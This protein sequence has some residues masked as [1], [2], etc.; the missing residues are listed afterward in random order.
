MKARL[1]IA[2]VSTLLEEVLLVVGVLWGLP[3]LGINLPGWGLILMMLAWATLAV[4]TY[5]MGSRALRRRPLDGLTAML[6]SKGEAVSP[7]APEGM[8]R[9]RG[10]L[11]RARSVDGE[12]GAG[13]EVTVVGQ[14]RLKLTVS[15]RRPP[16]SGGG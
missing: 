15:R 9:I 3:R 13:E 7:L 4:V 11:W 12:I 1:V 5:R 6:D 10:E 14:D 2:V 16:G 8:V